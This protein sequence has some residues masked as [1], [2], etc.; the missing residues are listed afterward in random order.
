MKVKV[1]IAVVSIGVA[2]AFGR[3]TTPERIKI[4]KVIVEVEKKTKDS[5]TDAE[6]NKRRETTTR[7]VTHPDGTKEVI[8]TVV[9]TTETSKK[10]N[11]HETDKISKKEKDSKEI[12]KNSNTFN[13]SL[14]TGAKLPSGGS[15]SPLIYGGHITKQILGP[16]NVGVWG[17]SDSTGGVSLGLSF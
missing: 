14:L 7:E 9:E 3:Y 12:V 17:L 4:E 16:I 15:L 10:S 8:T 6:R 5:N 13:L 2:F 11:T 1:F